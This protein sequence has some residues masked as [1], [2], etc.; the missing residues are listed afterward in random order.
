[1]ERS[2][3]AT[4]QAILQ[5]SGGWPQR[6]ANGAFVVAANTSEQSFTLTTIDDYRDR[7]LTSV[8]VDSTQTRVVFRLY[9]QGQLYFAVVLARFAAGNE[10]LMFDVAIPAQ[11]LIT[12]SFQDPAGTGI[13]NVN[14][15]LGYRP[16]PAM[17]M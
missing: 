11:Q 1:M 9:S 3:M 10:E 15:T 14:A 5:S 8:F 17:G 13:A 6:Y 2:N 16:D 7:R 12:V 4:P